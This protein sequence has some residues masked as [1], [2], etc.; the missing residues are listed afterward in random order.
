[1]ELVWHGE[2]N[3][4]FQSLLPHRWFLN[5]TFSLPKGRKWIMFKDSA[6]VRFLCKVGTV[7]ETEH[8]VLT[9]PAH[10]NTL[11]NIHFCKGAVRCAIK[12]FS[13]TKHST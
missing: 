2:F 1:M 3:R 8:C 11:I 12:A 7:T 9:Y 6:K 13:L 4:L 5:P 10:S